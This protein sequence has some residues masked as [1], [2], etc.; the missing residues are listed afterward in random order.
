MRCA[1]M[2]R[3]DFFYEEF[4]RGWLL[5]EVNTIPGFTPGSMYPKLWDAT[6]L[7]YPTS[8]TAWS[9]SRSNR[10]AVVPG[11]PPNTDVASIP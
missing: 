5:N 11:S 6:G 2:A 10:I 4:G 9:R 3:V 8:S 1:G 7:P